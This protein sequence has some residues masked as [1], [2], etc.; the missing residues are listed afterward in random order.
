MSGKPPK[1]TDL[2]AY[3]RKVAA[4]VR[5]MPALAPLAYSRA[6]AHVRAQVAKPENRNQRLEL[7]AI[8]NK[9]D[10]L[11]AEAII[12][13]ADP[14]DV[15]LI[16]PWADDPS[17]Q[18]PTEFDGVVADI[19]ES[20]VLPNGDPASELA[21]DAAFSRFQK[22][23][24]YEVSKPV[25]IT[26]ESANND[27]NL[28][29]NTVLVQYGGTAG[30]GS[31]VN[32]GGVA[33][34][35]VA[36]QEVEIVRWDG[37]GNGEAVPCRV[38]ISRLVGGA[39]A[40][41]PTGPTGAVNTYYNYRPFFHA[42]WGSGERGQVNEVYGDV[43]RG[44]QFTVNACHIYVN[45]GM[46]PFTAQTSLFGTVNYQP[47]AMYLNGHLGFFAGV[48]GAPV[49]RTTY[50]DQIAGSATS[51]II[52][53]LFAQYLLPPQ[54]TATSGTVQIDFQDNSGTTI[55][56][57]NFATGGVISPIPIADDVYQVV[58]TNNTGADAG[59]RLVFQLSL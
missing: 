1:V 46:D 39:N 18:I 11:A 58:L 36:K 7:Q 2:N 4:I 47:G 42:F 54:S 51:T 21:A 29:S 50:I 24:R 44:I 19:A 22:A 31:F 34:P 49:T 40:T 20:K 6:A 38:S 35:V 5:E 9:L 25:Q 13:E 32:A 16:S 10:E 37:N 41:F 30:S 14:V 43:G 26:P 33:G 56:S 55:Y 52:V 3:M 23:R 48:S 17:G 8:A 15:E 27:S 59:F 53:P 12:P 45:V 57:L 28:F